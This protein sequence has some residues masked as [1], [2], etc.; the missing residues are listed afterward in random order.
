MV[1]DKNTKVWSYPY[2]NNAVSKSLYDLKI[3]HYKFWN[4]YDRIIPLAF[5][6]TGNIAPRSRKFINKL[7]APSS[8]DNGTGVQRN[9]NSEIQR[10][11]LKKNFLDSISLLFAKYRVKDIQN[12]DRVPL[13][14]RLDAEAERDPI[15]QRRRQRAAREAR[16]E[17]ERRNMARE[18]E[19]GQ[20]R[21][22]RIREDAVIAHE[23][24]LQDLLQ[25]EQRIRR[26]TR[27]AIEAL[28][29]ATNLQNLQQE[30]TIDLEAIQDTD[31]QI[32]M[33][34]FNIHSLY[35]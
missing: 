9:W 35:N 29:D 18:E 6:S 16:E 11:F 4:H 33:D 31:V 20:S 22:E 7:Y 19:E 34:N 32:F 14:R 17:E 3:K 28:G 23:L 15:E 12:M 10:R 27:V 21:L 1:K 25:E 24:Y 5:D 8:G 13:Q 26:E 2:V 30:T